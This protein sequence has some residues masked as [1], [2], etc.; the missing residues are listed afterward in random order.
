MVP[1]RISQPST[2][3][4]TPRL[5]GFPLQTNPKG[6]FPVPAILLIQ[7]LGC[8]IFSELAKVMAFGDLW[9]RGKPKAERVSLGHLWKEGSLGRVGK[10]CTPAKLACRFFSG[11]SPVPIP[12]P[13]DKWLN[14]LPD[15]PQQVRQSVFRKQ[16]PLPG[17]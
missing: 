1:K 13:G 8:V 3:W 6:H 12:R 16:V 2:V 11:S 4:R 15:W 14:S 7:P 5:L 17:L 10:L 9:Q